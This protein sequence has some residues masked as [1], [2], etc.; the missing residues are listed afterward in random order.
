[1]ARET[2]VVRTV[3]FR[4]FGGDPPLS[5]TSSVEFILSTPEKIE[6]QVCI[7]EDLAIL[8]TTPQELRS[9]LESLLYNVPEHQYQL[10]ASGSKDYDCRVT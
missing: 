3:S 10:T 5:P 8:Y 7:G 4:H 9:H 1:M 2:H 6:I